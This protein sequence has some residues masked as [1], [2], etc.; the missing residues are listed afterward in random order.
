M[1]VC[2]EQSRCRRLAS[3]FMRPPPT[4]D[5]RNAP[6][7]HKANESRRVHRGRRSPG[8]TG[9]AV[10]TG[11]LAQTTFIVYVN[12]CCVH[13]L[14]VLRNAPSREYSSSV[15]FA[16]TR[17][18]NILVFLYYALCVYAKDIFYEV[19]ER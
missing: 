3:A 6:A 8:E 12:L 17:E 19:I 13:W 1:F 9:A 7:P 11:I 4:R 16:F 10:T 14:F 18:E 2:R 15:Q 5:L